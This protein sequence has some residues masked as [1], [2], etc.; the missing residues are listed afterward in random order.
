MIFQFVFRKHFFLRTLHYYFIGC[1]ICLYLFCLFYKVILRVRIV[2]WN[3]PDNFNLTKF[4][5]TYILIIQIG[6]GTII[7]VI[8]HFIQIIIFIRQVFI[9]ITMIIIFL[10]IISF[11]LRI[12]LILS[13]FLFKN[14]ENVDVIT[15]IAE[16][17]TC[18]QQYYSQSDSSDIWF[19][20]LAN[21]KSELAWKNIDKQ[22]GSVI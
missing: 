6:V 8:I 2:Y 1:A 15:E 4:V 7:F 21:K 10:A 12:S 14:L 11:S 17:Q 22:V 20:K 18:Y 16:Y 19:Q 5:I 3:S 9:F 13:V